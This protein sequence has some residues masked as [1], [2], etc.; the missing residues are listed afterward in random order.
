MGKYISLAALLL[1]ATPVHAGE[2]KTMEAGSIA[3][4]AYRGVVLYTSE[5]DGY[6]VV[7][8][9]ADGESGLPVRFEARNLRSR[10]GWRTEPGVRDVASRQQARHRPALLSLS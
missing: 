9:I 2:L 7:A 1:I 8:T 10:Q 3:V 5:H 4:G 6:H